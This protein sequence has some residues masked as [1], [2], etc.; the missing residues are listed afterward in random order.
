MFLF[1][2]FRDIFF[3]PKDFK[4]TMSSFYYY[5]SQK[6]KET[7]GNIFVQTAKI[8]PKNLETTKSNFEKPSKICRGENCFI[9]RVQTNKIFSY[10]RKLIILI[11]DTLIKVKHFSQ[12]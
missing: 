8:V 6:N 9:G 12:H 5:K 11:S 4:R 2:C 1:Y 7:L 10:K 3:F